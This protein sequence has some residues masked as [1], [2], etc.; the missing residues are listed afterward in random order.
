MEMDDKVPKF[1]PTVKIA[2]GDGSVGPQ[3]FE[4]VTESQLQDYE[5]SEHTQKYYY[6]HGCSAR[7]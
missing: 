2:R 1:D 3:P 6:Y 4:L 5:V 7:G